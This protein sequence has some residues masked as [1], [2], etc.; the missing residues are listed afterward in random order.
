MVI[1]VDSQFQRTGLGV[2][3]E[4]ACLANGVQIR[5]VSSQVS[6]VIVFK[7]KEYR[8]QTGAVE[9]KRETDLAVVLQMSDMI[10]LISQVGYLTDS[11]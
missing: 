4:A 5:F 2:A 1:E 10:S 11:F 9:M 8:P 3:V 7:R 6:N